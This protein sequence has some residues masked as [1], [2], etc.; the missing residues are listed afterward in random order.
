MLLGQLLHDALGLTSF[1]LEELVGEV[2]L[3][4]RRGV[5]LLEDQLLFV[6]LLGGGFGN[7]ILQDLDASRGFGQGR[8]QLLD[9]ELVR[10]ITLFKDSILTPKE[11]TFF[12][13]TFNSLF[14]LEQ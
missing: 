4:V 11:L 8:I 3:P 14:H 2:G 1:T 13:Q 7:P 9:H 12:L 10:V 6:L 5:L